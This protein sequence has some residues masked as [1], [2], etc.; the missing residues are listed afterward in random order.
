MVYEV[1]SFHFAENSKVLEEM[2]LD[3]ETGRLLTGEYK[4]K[5]IPIILDWLK[6]HQEKK[7]K[8]LPKAAKILEEAG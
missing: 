5:Y 3:M 6:A 1:M 4:L 8:L 2:R 7:K